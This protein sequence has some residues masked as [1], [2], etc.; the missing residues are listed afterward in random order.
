MAAGRINV[1]HLGQPRVLGSACLAALATALAGYP[2]LS[3][4]LNRPDSV[5]FLEAIIFLC[6]IV[7]WGFVFAWQMPYAHR[8]VF[9]FKVEAGPFIAATLAGMAAALVFYLWFDPL[10]RT[11][12][13][14]EYPANP[15]EWF[16]FTLFLLAFKQVFVIFAPFAWLM[17]LLHN[18]RVATLLTVLFGALVLTLNA[19]HSTTPISTTLFAA[20]LVARIG[21]GFL[22]VSFYLHGGVILVWWWTLLFEARHWFYLAHHS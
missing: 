8:P 14:E 9:I 15:E 5:W 3:L 20:L 13:P 11:K 4:W 1:R 7:L 10:L 2:R 21:M 22:S 16:A 17:R 18:R 19:R 12:V 6:S